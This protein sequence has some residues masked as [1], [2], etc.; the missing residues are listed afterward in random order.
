[1]PLWFALYETDLVGTLQ[2][3][4]GRHAHLVHTSQT[5]VVFNDT[6]GS[7]VSARHRPTIGTDTYSTTQTTSSKM[8]AWPAHEFVFGPLAAYPDLLNRYLAA[9]LSMGATAAQ[10]LVPTAKKAKTQAAGDISTGVQNLKET[11]QWR[12]HL[13]GMLRP[14]N[15]G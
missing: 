5:H 9:K 6:G 8:K 1:M 12:N 13:Q 15:K 7:A 11:I 3:G 2:G 4:H 10:R 14:T